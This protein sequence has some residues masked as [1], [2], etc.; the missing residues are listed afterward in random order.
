MIDETDGPQPGAE[1]IAVEQEQVAQVETNADATTA[2]TEDTAD[3]GDDDGSDDTAN[4]EGQARKPSKGFQKRADELTRQRHEAQRERDYWREMAMRQAPAKEAA[5]PAPT[6]P[7]TL[8]QYDYDEAA[9]NAASRKFYA[10]EAK[11]VARAAIAE[12]RAQVTVQ[13]RL[14][15]AK[16]KHADFDEVAER[17]DMT[18]VVSAA[19]AED[20]EAFDVLLTIGRDERAAAQFNQMTPFQQAVE[21]G[22]IKASLAK[23]AS[24][25]LRNP[26]PPPP[27]TVSGM[28]AGVSKDPANMSMDE[29]AAWRRAN[30]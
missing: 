29:Y 30:P 16:S 4:T 13:Q 6:E 2:E 11:A 10:D 1:A 8:D 3:T 27:K 26:P 19:V 20:A 17:I 9:F 12:E 18:D 21:I 14:N 15:D 22:R 25:T 28:T 24:P 5:P 23:T 7:P